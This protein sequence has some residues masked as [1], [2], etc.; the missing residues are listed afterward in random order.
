MTSSK[1]KPD[2]DVT[3]MGFGRFGFTIGLIGLFFLGMSPTAIAQMSKPIRLA[4]PTKVAPPDSAHQIPGR[5]NGN[6]SNPRIQGVSKRITGGRVEVDNLQA[7][8]ASEVGILTNQTGALGGQMWRG[9]SG[10]LVERLIGNLPT[11]APSAAM[12]DLMRRLLLSPGVAPEGISDPNYLI[13]MRFNTLM[14][15]GALD[16]A[17]KL[18]DALPS[19]RVAKLTALE[20]D[21]RFLA[22]DNARACTLAEQEI[23]IATSA[24]WQKSFTFCSILKGEKEKALLSLSLMREL[25]EEDQTFLALAE[26]LISGEDFELSEMD[27]PSPL[28]LAMSRVGN[29]QLPGSVISSNIPS[30]LRAIAMSPKASIALRLEAGERADAAGALPVDVLRQM[31][32]S[33]TFS[34]EDLANPL[35]RAEVEFGPMVRALLFRTSLAQTIPIA[36]AEAAARAFALARDEGRYTSTVHVFWPI[37]KRI[38]PSNELLWFAPEALRALLLVGDRDAALPW[39]QILQAGA[40]RN[41]DAAK[42]IALFGPLAHL[43]KFDV[44]RQQNTDQLVSLWWAA[45]QDQPESKEKAMLLFTILQSLGLKISEKYWQPLIGMD[46]RSQKTMPSVGLLNRLRRLTVNAEM[47]AAEPTTPNMAPVL[48]PEQ[49]SALVASVLIS[50]APELTPVQL[51]EPER[52]LMSKRVGET[53]MLSL[54]AI[55]DVGPAK[56]EVGVLSTVLKALSSVGLKAD[57]RALALEAALTNGL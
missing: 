22:N 48:A 5:G 35:S 29:V 23:A 2:F 46:L 13:L 53:V 42:A 33:V 15:I 11:R 52:P 8:D 37:L 1:N 4:P 24:F 45:I 17:S 19:A 50:P 28:H 14:T 25:G 49:V 41:A 55:G 57:A 54:L 21:L 34:E 43:F 31:Y 47:M 36:Q 20:V 27:N 3:K 30:V 56:I 12:R 51:Q 40:A 32:A 6:I 39:Y 7:V 10:A 44:V 26:G 38:V 16:D 9:T 18:F